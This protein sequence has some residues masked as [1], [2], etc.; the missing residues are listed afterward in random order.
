MV[1]TDE[2]VGPYLYQIRLLRGHMFHLPGAL[3]PSTVKG[4]VLNSM[5]SEEVKKR[6][7]IT[8]SLLHLANSLL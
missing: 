1:W 3:P 8:Y 6:N 5:V 4:G 2:P 7:N